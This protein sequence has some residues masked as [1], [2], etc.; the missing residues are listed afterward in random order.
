MSV[1]RAALLALIAAGCAG[2]SPPPEPDGPRAAGTADTIG[3]ASSRSGGVAIAGRVVG[4]ETSEPVVGAYVVV[5]RPEVTLTEWEAASGPESEALMEAATVTDESGVYEILDLSRGEEYT[6][7][8]ASEGYE[9]AVFDRGL[10][11]RR[12]DP[13][14]VRP[15]TV[16][17]DRRPR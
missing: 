16:R 14:V 11:I 10:T 1:A 9:A 7:I 3:P 15:E 6:L 12:D 8:V 5:L 2:D 13:P 17:L 4:G